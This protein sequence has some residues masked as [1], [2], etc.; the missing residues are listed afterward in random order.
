MNT[1]KLNK[2]GTRINEI[3]NFFNDW[4]Q[5]NPTII[6]YINQNVV[7]LDTIQTI[8]GSKTFSGLAHFDNMAYF[9]DGYSLGNHTSIFDS[10]TAGVINIQYGSTGSS[11]NSYLKI[12]NAG[13]YDNP[14]ILATLNDIPSVLTPSDADK[15]KFLHVNNSDGSLEWTNVNADNFYHTP[16]YSSGLQIGIGNGVNDLYVPDA[17]LHQSGVIT[18][19]SQIIN[20]IKTFDSG[21]IKFTGTSGNIPTFG[22]YLGDAFYITNG[23]AGSLIIG[24]PHSAP[25]IGLFDTVTFNNT[26]NISISRPHSSTNNSYLKFPEGRGNIS[27]SETLLTEEKADTKYVTR[28]GATNVV[29][30]DDPDGPFNFL[31]GYALV[32]IDKFSN[33]D[34]FVDGLYMFTY[35]HVQGY[36]YLS[37]AEF[38]QTAV[39]APIPVNLA[40]SSYTYPGTL[41][42]E[43]SGANMKITITCTV[44]GGN[45]QTVSSGDTIS[46]W[47][48]D[49]I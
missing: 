40:G 3:L 2:T 6:N 45:T 46:I 44:P 34:I 15:N 20:G 23:T 18:T 21:V 17:G 36:I 22:Y 43:K 28:T 48:L 35:R 38:S 16:E 33:N 47:R 19:G 13:T 14:A 7:T 5:T 30:V 41:K 32:P 26:G 4:P 1:F 24:N 31:N 49:L 8:T 29:P 42:V 9:Y 37:F 11:V 10:G 39:R 27:I 25:R 12:P